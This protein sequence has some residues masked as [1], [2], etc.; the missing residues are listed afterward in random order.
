M[1]QLIKVIYYELVK[2]TI[3]LLDLAEVIIDI[4][5]YYYKVSESIVM[6]EVG[7]LR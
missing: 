2:I 3:N 7:Y 5:V 4:I 1:D 6:I